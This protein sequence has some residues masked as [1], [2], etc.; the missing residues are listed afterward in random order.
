MFSSYMN[1][2]SNYAKYIRYEFYQ[3]IHSCNQDQL[4]SNFVVHTSTTTSHTARW[5]RTPPLSTPSTYLLY[6]FFNRIH[7]HLTYLF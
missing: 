4:D 3:K 2:L 6:S 1:N 5:Y 7:L